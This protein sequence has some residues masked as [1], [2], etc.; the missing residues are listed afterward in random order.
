MHTFVAVDEVGREL[1][2][3][4]VAA[5]S[6]GHA[7]AVTWAREV[8]RLPTVQNPYSR[9]VDGTTGRL[10]I[11]LSGG[12]VQILGPRSKPPSVGAAGSPMPVLTDTTPT[13]GEV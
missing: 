4:V 6:A 11:G 3:K 9:G 7:E 2:E 5:P 10:F 12:V 1:A 8:E 13:L